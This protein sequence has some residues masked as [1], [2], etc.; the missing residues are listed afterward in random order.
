MLR[1]LSRIAPI[2]F[3]QYLQFTPRMGTHS[4]A[5]TALFSC[6]LDTEAVFSPQLAFN[7]INLCDCEAFELS[8][9]QTVLYR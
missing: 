3:Q 7:V 1:T 5:E 6:A 4:Q 2:L 8:C 9:V